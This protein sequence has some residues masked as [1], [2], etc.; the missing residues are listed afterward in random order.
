MIEEETTRGF[1]FGALRSAIEGKDPDL[2]LGFYSEDAKLRV[3]NG[4]APEGSAFELRGRSQIERYLRAVSDQ[5]MSCLVEGEVVFGEGSITFGQVCAY[6]DGTRVAVGT[7][8]EIGEG[9]IR[10][11]LDVARGAPRD[12]GSER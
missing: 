10:R 4:D 11:Q 9:K 2:L 12:D 7:T 8:L 6:P 3:V 5:Q 1:D